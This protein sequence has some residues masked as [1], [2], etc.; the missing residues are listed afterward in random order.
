VKTTASRTP[1][2]RNAGRDLGVEAK[3]VLEE[4]A[5]ETDRIEH[6]DLRS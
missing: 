1:R 3:E 6:G 2:R 5:R 4:V